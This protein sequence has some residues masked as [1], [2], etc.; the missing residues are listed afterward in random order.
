[1]RRPRMTL[2]W[3]AIVI[4]VAAVDLTLVTPRDSHPLAMLAL[5]A[6]VLLLPVILVLFVFAAR[7]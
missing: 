3:W 1:M 5:Y 7:D 4:A 6:N 2:R